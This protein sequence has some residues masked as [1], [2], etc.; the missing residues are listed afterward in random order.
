MTSDVK[1]SKWWRT[2]S[3]RAAFRRVAKARRE[4]FKALRKRAAQVKQTYAE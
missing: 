4:K 1:L 3:A 2:P